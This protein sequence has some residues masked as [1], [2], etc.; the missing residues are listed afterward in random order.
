MGCTMLASDDLDAN[1]DVWIVVH[2]Q[3]LGKSKTPK[4]KY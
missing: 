3:I 2:G 1:S 4:F